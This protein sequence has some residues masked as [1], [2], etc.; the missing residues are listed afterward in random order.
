MVVDYLFF[1]S[2]VGG[3]PLD[4]LVDKTAKA[5]PVWAESVLLVVYYFW[6]CKKFLN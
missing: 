4:H 2:A 5:E 6:G 3:L 1:S